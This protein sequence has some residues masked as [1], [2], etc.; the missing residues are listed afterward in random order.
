M[1][2]VYREKVLEVTVRSFSEVTIF[3]LGPIGMEM[4]AIHV[5]EGRGGGM[6]LLI[7]F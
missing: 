6:C 3:L 5:D 1:K 7:N 4:E 2:K